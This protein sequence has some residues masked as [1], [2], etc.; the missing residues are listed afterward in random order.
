[1]PCCSEDCGTVRIAGVRDPALKATC[2]SEPT[3][4]A[5]AGSPFLLPAPE[6]VNPAGLSA[7]VASSPPLLVRPLLSLRI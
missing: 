6:G 3:Q 1:M 7:F 2:S 4:L 5:L